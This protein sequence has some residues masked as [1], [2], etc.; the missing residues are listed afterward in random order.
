M[1]TQTSDEFPTAVRYSPCRPKAANKPGPILLTEAEMT[2][3]AAA[4]GKAGT[5][6]GN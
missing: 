5:I 3:V 6:S 2:F 4:G 1:R